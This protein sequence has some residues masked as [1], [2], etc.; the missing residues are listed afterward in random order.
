MYSKKKGKIEN[1]EKEEYVRI[2]YPKELFNCDRELKLQK[3]AETTSNHVQLS[4]DTST[5]HS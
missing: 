5:K 1:R 3:L 4:K 2:H